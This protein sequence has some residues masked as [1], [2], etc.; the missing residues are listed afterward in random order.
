MLLWEP[1][2]PLLFL[3]TNEPHGV[4][5]HMQLFLSLSDI[6]YAVD[7]NPSGASVSLAIREEEK[8]MM[9]KLGGWGWGST[10]EPCGRQH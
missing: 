5:T 9:N 4:L 8:H 7:I 1:R 3:A 2:T 10:K 6:M